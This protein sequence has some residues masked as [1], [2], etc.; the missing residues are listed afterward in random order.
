MRKTAKTLDQ[1][2][3]DSQ[4][5]EKSDPAAAKAMSQAADTGNQQ[6]V[7]GKQAKA[8]DAAKQNQ[9]GEAQSNQKQAEL[10]LQMMLAD[11]RE[12]QKH[13]LDEL[14]RKLA[15]LQQQVAILIREQAGHNLDNLALQGALDKTSA[16]VKLDLF[17]KAERKTR[18]CR[19]CRWNLAC[20]VPRRNRPNGTRATSP[21]RRKTCPMVT[22]RRT[23]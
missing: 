16:T 9:Q 15:E 7:P 12:A 21:S 11:L 20:S 22:A 18:N 19:C 10:G 3:K 5:L 17:T 13:K 6:N 8:A 1:I 14:A 4:K 2:A 23:I